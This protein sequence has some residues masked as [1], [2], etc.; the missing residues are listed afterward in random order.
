MS[1]AKRLLQFLAVLAAL[2]PL[3]LY[4]WQGQ[5]LRPIIDDYYT[6]RIGRELGAWDGMLFHYN[7][8]SGGY[9]NFYIKSAMWLIAALWL[10]CALL[11]RLGGLHANAPARAGNR[12][13]GVF[14]PGMGACLGCLTK[15]WLQER[16]A[17]KVWLS[18]LGLC[19]AIVALMIGVD[20]AAGQARLIPRLAD[21]AREWDDR[22][23]SI[24]ERRDR[25]ERD[26]TVQPLNFDMH[27]FLAHSSDREVHFR[28]ALDYYGVDS[29]TEVESWGHCLERQIAPGHKNCI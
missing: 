4:A 15:Q 22:S 26:I 12:C 6:L 1:K 7:T 20:V 5:Y 16:R 17:A 9:A 23:Q 27:R 8:W 21:F 18:R 2:L 11:P 25:G 10:A 19:S 13:Y 14:R 24:I 29:I 28:Y 3:V